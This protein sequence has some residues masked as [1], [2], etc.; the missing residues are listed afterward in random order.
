MD[1]AI[2]NISSTDAASPSATPPSTAGPS[3]SPPS[4]QCSF[5]QFVSKMA[6]GLDKCFMCVSFLFEGICLVCYTML[7]YSAYQCHSRLVKL[8]GIGNPLNMTQNTEVRCFILSSWKQ[9]FSL[10][11]LLNFRQMVL[12]C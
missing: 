4:S 5:Y 8:A 12:L 1:G 10:F 6:K 11:K 7:G 2:M 9:R 3:S